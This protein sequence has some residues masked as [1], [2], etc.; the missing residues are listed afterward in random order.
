MP[1]SGCTNGVLA[2]ALVVL[3]LLPVQ[4]Y[5]PDLYSP[6]PEPVLTPP[7]S[8][9]TLSWVQLDEYPLFDTV[10]ATTLVVLAFFIY[11]CDWVQRKVLERRIF[12][13][14][15]YLGECVD[16]LRGW[17]T[18]QEQLETMLHT[19]R[20]ATA[21]YSL[22]LYLMLRKHRLVAHKGPPPT[23][24]LEKELDDLPFVRN[25]V[26]EMQME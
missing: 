22:L 7:P 1:L 15:Q 17:D 26:L 9:Y 14:N 25:Y 13:L 23:S 4:Y 19:V 8:T 6:V 11:V 16:K 18:R 3:L 2:T 10:V 12:K 24:L 5:V 20:N 21:E